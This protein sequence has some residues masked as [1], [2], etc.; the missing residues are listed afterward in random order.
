[1]PFLHVAACFRVD[2]IGC[3]NKR[4]LKVAVRR[5]EFHVAVCGRSKVDGS[6]LIRFALMVFSW[7]GSARSVVSCRIA[8]FTRCQARVLG[9][10]AD[11]GWL[12]GRGKYRFFT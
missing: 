10:E 2:V 5:P 8:T 7:S 6:V 1:M 3:V 4:A 12:V 11:F 9:V